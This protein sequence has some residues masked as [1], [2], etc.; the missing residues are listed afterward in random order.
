[1]QN[2]EKIF[3]KEL[4]R[5]HEALQEKKTHLKEDKFKEMDTDSEGES[6]PEELTQLNSHEDDILKIVTLK[7]N[8]SKNDKNPKPQSF[9]TQQIQVQPPEGLANSVGGSVKD[10]SWA[11]SIPIST[12]FLKQSSLKDIT[13]RAKAG[14][15]A[16]DIQ[17]EAHMAFAL[18]NLNEEAKEYKKAIKFY[19][20]FFFCARILEDPVG[21]SLG[22]NRLGVMYHKIKNYSKLHFLPIYRQIAPVSSETQAVHRR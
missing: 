6:K 4:D 13:M 3:D 10:S 8:S 2:S 15:Q 7:F 12:A 22:L 9:F 20:R 17:K 11:P 21:A 14:V 5:E 16:G 19:K 18:G 1:M